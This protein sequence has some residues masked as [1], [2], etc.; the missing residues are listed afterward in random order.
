MKE[1]LQAIARE[2]MEKLESVRDVKTL[3]EIR[4]LFLG[5]KG[6]L[7]G[8]LK[9]MGTLPADER[10]V[11]GQLVNEIREQLEDN[12]A[13]I[14]NRLLQEERERKM[15]RET[16]DVTMPGT[17]HPMGKKHPLTQVLDEI[18][19]VFL[20]MG[21][22]IA[23]GPEVELDYYNFEALN[24]PKNHP[25]RDTQDSFY[26]NENVVLRTQ[27]SPVQIRVMENKKPPIKIICPGRVYRSDQVDATHSP[28][29]HQVEG[30]VVDKGVTMGDLIGT[31]QVFAKSLFG[32]NTKIR[33][34]PHHFPFTEPSAEVDVSCWSCGGKGCRVC[35]NEGWIEILGA[36]MVH[37]KVLE[38]CGIDPKVYSGFAFGLGVER[39]AM[40]RFNIDDMRL[41]YENDMRFLKQF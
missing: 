38:I 13:K 41:L 8:I 33:L 15:L 5:K 27:T 4:V 32:E 30:L 31:L 9:G 35:K 11:V 20:G 22:E 14:K 21:Y 1:Q 36:G 2:A 7:T 3:E 18:K 6:K 23:E 12:I 19:E 10:P 29:F 24:I 34:R 28:I 16:I 39:T 25:A 40:G 17:L 37:P 26:I